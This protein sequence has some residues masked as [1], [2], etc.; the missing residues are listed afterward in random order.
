MS[1]SYS[2]DPSA[3]RL[4]AV[5]F[6]CRD[7]D[8]ATYIVEDEEITWTLTQEDGVYSAAAAIA[9][10]IALKYS[11]QGDVKFGP[12]EVSNRA[13]GFRDM[14]KDL[15]MRAM[16]REAQIIAPVD[17]AEVIALTV[18]ASLATTLCRVYGT[19]ITEEGEAAQNVKISFTPTAVYPVTVG[20]TILDTTPRT[21]TTDSTGLFEVMLVR[22]T[23]MTV[24]TPGDSVTY[25]I[26]CTVGRLNGA[27]IT[28][29]AAAS[30]DVST[31][32]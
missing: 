25:K 20:A 29:P 3:S 17:A 27:E 28:V 7:I 14:A 32:L 26:T 13:A 4:D 23:S 24:T 16:L 30:V 31:L 9:D 5:R 11:A 19:L 10:S 15:R 22:S 21:V 1:F 2:G 6:L 18:P 8:V 12:S